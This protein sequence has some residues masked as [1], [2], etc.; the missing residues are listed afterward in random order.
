MSDLRT[1]QVG[2]GAAGF[3]FLPVYF[4]QRRGVFAARGLAVEVKRMGSTEKATAAVR[5]GELNIAI[6]PPEGAIRDCAAGGDLRIV[7]GNVN[8]LPLTMIANP[9]FKRIEDLRGARLGTSS[10]SEGT[11]LYTMEVMRRHGLNYIRATTSL[12]SWAST[13][14]AGGRCR[15]ERST[16][17]CSFCRSIS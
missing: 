16:R 5:S 13:R 10:M 11:A 7:G 2:A 4:G 1:I 15:R 14:R 12:R 3:N 8:R 17:P 6:T 9:R